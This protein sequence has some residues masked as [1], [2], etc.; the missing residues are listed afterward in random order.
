MVATPTAA[1]DQRVEG[2]TGAL[3]A[4]AQ[5]SR[6]ARALGPRLGVLGNAL[7]VLSQLGDLTLGVRA[8]RDALTG[9]GRLEIGNGG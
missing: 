2:V 1:P 5:A 4:K 7:R 6:L 3:V 9:S 8:E